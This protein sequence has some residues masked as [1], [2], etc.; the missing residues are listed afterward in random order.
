MSHK[1][2]GYGI[3]FVQSRQQCFHPRQIAEFIAAG[4]HAHAPS[5]PIGSIEQIGVGD[6][7]SASFANLTIRQKAA[8]L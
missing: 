5:F 7:Q 2:P 6:E 3:A 4:Q 1:I 8:L